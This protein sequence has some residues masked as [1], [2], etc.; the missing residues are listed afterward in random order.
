MWIPGHDFSCRYRPA[1]SVQVVLALPFLYMERVAE[2]V[3][4]M[5][6]V[7]VAAQGVSP[8]PPGRYTCATPAAWLKGLAGYVV[9][10]H[11]ERRY[12]FHEDNQSVASQVR[13]SVTAGLRPILCLDH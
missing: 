6:Q 11:R 3:G 12:Y 1:S 5:E 8:Y 4:G 2:K 9:V 13:E 7:K 10:G